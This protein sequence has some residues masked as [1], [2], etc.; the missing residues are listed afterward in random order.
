LD[1]TALLVQ[2]P[3]VETILEEA[4]RLNADLIILGSHGRGAAIQLLVGSVSGGVL[5]KSKCPV[6]IVP[7]RKQA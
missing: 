7:T 4:T 2:G 5:Q 3:T 6:L 1:A